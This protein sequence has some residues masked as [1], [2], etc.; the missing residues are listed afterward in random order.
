MKTAQWRAKAPKKT[1][2][3]QITE[4]INKLNLFKAKK[5]EH[6]INEINYIIY[7]NQGIL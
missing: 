7:K 3:W 1:D 4:K 6:L 5:Y 2:I